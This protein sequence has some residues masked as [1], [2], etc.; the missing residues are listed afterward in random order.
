MKF[1]S[2]F[3]ALCSAALLTACD[4]SNDTPNPTEGT[5]DGLLFATSVTNPEGSS[6]SCYLQAIA[7]LSTAV[8]DN[9]KSIPTGFGTPIIVSGKN[10]YVLPDYMGQNK[11]VLT[12]YKVDKNKNFVP[13]G[14]LSLPGAAGACNVVQ[15]SE[16]KGYVA[17]QNLGKVMVFNPAT[18]TK[19][20][21]IDLN[22][23]A[24]PE[25]RVAP[26]TM[27]ER[28]GLL[29]VG[30][31]QFDAKWMPKYKM[32]ELALI[33]TK[34]DKLVKHIKDEKH[35][36]SFATR[37]IDPGSM[38]MD[39]VGDIYVNCIGSF[40]LMPGYKAGLIRIRKGQT[41]FD[42]D[43]VIDF[44]TTQ[45]EGLPTGADFLA[46]VYYGGNGK[47]YA[48]ANSYRLDPKGMSNPYTAKSSAPVVI[49]LKARSAR[50]IMGL[51]ISNPHAV[52]V[53][54][55]KGKALFGSTNE[56][57]SGFYTY[58]PAT[59]K[60]EGP[61]IQVKGNPFCILKY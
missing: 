7:D 1:K 35:E 51:P 48:Y 61:V 25:T 19:T 34:T 31:S 29:Y 24:H 47:L 42:P 9:S 10:V 22:S 55:Y 30:L 39:E 8:Y 50:R 41:D 23:L 2:L 33:D 38:F 4:S 27:L 17:L 44:S 12:R 54:A 58:D 21:E 60:A 40:G 43:Y 45:V 49:D 59:D 32:A 18:M 11:S 13:Q 36:L 15:V 3:I 20:G 37:P 14:E 56:K 28:D 46:A 5:F 57:A 52:A 26:A 6:G 16:T 53:H